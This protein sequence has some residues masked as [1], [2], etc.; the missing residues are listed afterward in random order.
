MQ[1]IIKSLFKLRNL[2]SE[3][4]QTRSA[5][6]GKPKG[7]SRRGMGADASPAAASD[8]AP[9]P[10]IP[11]RR[12]SSSSNQVYTPPPPCAIPPGGGGGGLAECLFFLAE[13]RLWFC[14]ADVCLTVD[15]HTTRL[16][17]RG[18]GGGLSA[19]WWGRQRSPEGGGGGGDANSGIVATSYSMGKV[20]NPHAQ[21]RC[22]TARPGLPPPGPL[23]PRWASSTST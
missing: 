12:P 21:K 8:R 5:G 7:L 6:R 3:I 2:S 23:P 15:K 1:L 18:G 13:R 14:C 19:P 9:A 20:G 22:R 4:L 16:H 10:P 11:I 17:A